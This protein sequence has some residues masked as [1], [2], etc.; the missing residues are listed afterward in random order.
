MDKYFAWRLHF[1]AFSKSLSTPLTSLQPAFPCCR[2][3]LL[4]Y[5]LRKKNIH[6]IF[7]MQFINHNLDF[8]TAKNTF[9]H[10]H[11]KCLGCNADQLRNVCL[12][13]V[14]FCKNPTEFVCFNQYNSSFLVLTWT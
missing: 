6:R 11:V 5:F 12:R 10:T 7:N 9:L 4:G 13:F 2:S 3:N 1:L 14:V 8:V